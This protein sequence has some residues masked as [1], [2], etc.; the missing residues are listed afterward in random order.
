MKLY[1]GRGPLLDPLCVTS[2][3]LAWKL[4]REKRNIEC[5]MS[6]VEVNPSRTRLCDS[7]FAMSTGSIEADLSVVGVLAARVMEGAVIAAGKNAETLCGFKCYAD[8]KF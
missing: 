4:K 5:G 2:L 8:L 1:V 3:Q 6:N 7:I